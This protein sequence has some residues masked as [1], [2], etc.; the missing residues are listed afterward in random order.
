MVIPK[1]PAFFN[2]ST[3]SHGYCSLRSTSAARGAMISRA[4]F[5]ARVLRSF[6]VAFSV[7]ENFLPW[8]SPTLTPDTPYLDGADIRHQTSLEMENIHDDR[9]RGS[10]SEGQTRSQPHSRLRRRRPR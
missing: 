8:A 5:R 7:I 9:F 10:T 1:K 3:L 2:A 4:S 6:W